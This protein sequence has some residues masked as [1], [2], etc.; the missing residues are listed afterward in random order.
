MTYRNLNTNGSYTLQTG[1]GMLHTIVISTKGSGS[2]T[3]HVYDGTDATGPLIC[4]VDAH[5]QQVSLIYDLQ[6]ERGLHV[7]LAGGNAPD[8]TITYM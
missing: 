5:T 1:R 2:E 4:H 8:V 6:F 3:I 7:V